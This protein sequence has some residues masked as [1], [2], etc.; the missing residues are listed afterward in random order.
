MSASFTWTPSVDE[1]VEAVLELGRGRANS[2]LRASP[3][4]VAAAVPGDDLHDL[5]LLA[6]ELGEPR[7]ERDH[8]L[9]ERPHRPRALLASAGVKVRVHGG[10]PHLRDAV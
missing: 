2:A 1:L 9:G 3:T 10:G 7:P 8:P 6:L 5:A 4:A